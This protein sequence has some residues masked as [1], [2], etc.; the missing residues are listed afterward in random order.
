MIINYCEC[1]IICIYKLRPQK[2]TFI[3]CENALNTRCYTTSVG[4]CRKSKRQDD[5]LKVQYLSAI[6]SSCNPFLCHP[7]NS[8]QYYLMFLST[9]K[10]KGGFWSYIPLL[11]ILITNMVYFSMILVILYHV[12]FCC[13]HRGIYKIFTC[14]KK[15]D[16]QYSVILYS[17]SFHQVSAATQVGVARLVLHCSLLRCF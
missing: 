3:F 6:S 12:S 9:V 1:I 14:L 2:I 16:C 11:T 4:D 7:C 8:L 17:I 10:L 15:W 5:N 13:F